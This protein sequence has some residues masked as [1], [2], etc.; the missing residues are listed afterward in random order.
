MALVITYTTVMVMSVRGAVE[1][2]R[3]VQ[4]ADDVQ[5]KLLGLIAVGLFVV[6]GLVATLVM[7]WVMLR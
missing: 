3:F 1:A 4:G 2:L 5:S 7:G 6:V